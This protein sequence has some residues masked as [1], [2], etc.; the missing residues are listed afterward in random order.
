M[1]KG[2]VLKRQDHH[3]IVMTPDGRFHKIRSDGRDVIEGEEI[4]F[5]LPQEQRIRTMRRPWRNV[6]YAAAACL[7]LLLSGIPL[8]NLLFTTAYAAVSIDINPS[9]ELEVN[10]QYQVTDLHPLN[11]EAKTLAPSIAWKDRELTAVTSDIIQDAKKSGFLKQN[12]DILI[13]PVGLDNADASRE[14]L[15]KIEQQASVLAQQGGEGVTVTLMEGTKEARE[16]AQKEGMSVGKYALYDSVRHMDSSFSADQ[17]KK[18]SITEIS[19]AIG[20]IDR[21]PNAKHYTSQPT[22]KPDDILK[23]TVQPEVKRTTEPTATQPDKVTKVDTSKHESVSSKK[24]NHMPDTQ[25][26]G[27]KTKVIP[28]AVVEE[29]KRKAAAQE[30]KESGRTEEEKKY[31][32]E[33]GQLQ[34][35]QS[36]GGQAADD[37]EK[38]R[39]D[40]Y[41]K[42]R[43]KKQPH[44]SDPLQDE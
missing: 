16:A 42:E 11:E 17:I 6:T 26:S 37:E 41:K 30:K 2:I 5:A 3:W 44:F 7:L 20:G 23:P 29:T 21:V 8:W 36:Q 34:Q 38:K 18:L 32:S 14:V 13:V 27:P 10:K 39:N 28:K 31:K 1:K 9:F 24:E 19:S 40:S 12:Q 15:H 22:R 25:E 33:Y 35:E 43:E 4:E